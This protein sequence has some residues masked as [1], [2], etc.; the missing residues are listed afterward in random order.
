MVL[1]LFMPNMDGAEVILYLRSNLQ[2]IKV[3]ALSGHL[4]NGY[5]L[6]QTAKVLGAHDALA[7]PFSAEGFLQRVEALLSKT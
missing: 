4:F 1:N 6:C 3:L 5:N 2:S 7:K